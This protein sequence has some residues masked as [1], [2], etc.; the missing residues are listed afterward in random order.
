[1]VIITLQKHNY[2]VLAV[3]IMQ[4]GKKEK[5]WRRFI[6][7]QMMKHISIRQLKSCK[8]SRCPLLKFK[9]KHVTKH[10]IRQE[11]DIPTSHKHRLITNQAIASLH[12]KAESL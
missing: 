4:N 10:I 6:V 5:P 1:M 9:Q 3:I 2:L 8:V 11:D 12:L 7:I